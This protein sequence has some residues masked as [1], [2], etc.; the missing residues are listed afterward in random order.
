MNPKTRTTSRNTAITT[1][2]TEEEIE[3]FYANLNVNTY[4]AKMLCSLLYTIDRTKNVK[5][6][7]EE[8]IDLLVVQIDWSS[9]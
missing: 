5:E 1:I 2:D 4:M 9:I 6:R 7:L 3:T 8:T